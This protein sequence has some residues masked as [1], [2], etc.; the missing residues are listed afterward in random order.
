MSLNRG[1]RGGGQEDWAW[2]KEALDGL[3]SGSVEEMENEQVSGS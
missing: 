2:D 3:C 1:M